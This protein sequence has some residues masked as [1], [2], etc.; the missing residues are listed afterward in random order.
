[1]LS[2]HEFFTV[3]ILQ[4]IVLSKQQVSFNNHRYC[5]HK[6]YCECIHNETTT[7]RARF[8][9]RYPL[10]QR[11]L[12]LYGV[13]TDKDKLVYLHFRLQDQFFVEFIEIPPIFDNEQQ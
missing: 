7:E 9:M 8:Y 2:E 1:M 5:A 10:Y 4:P 3:P 13:F 12:P 11:T 6:P